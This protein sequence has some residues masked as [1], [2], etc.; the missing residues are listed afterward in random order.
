MNR[1]NGDIHSSRKEY[2]EHLHRNDEIASEN[3]TTDSIS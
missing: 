2:V 1:P 3:C